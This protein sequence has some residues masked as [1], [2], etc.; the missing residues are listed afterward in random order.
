MKGNRKMAVVGAVLGSLVL[1]LVLTKDAGI[2]AAFAA[3]CVGAGG[4]FFRANV[5]EHKTRGPQP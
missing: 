1:G 3:A 4:W 2:Y 5:D